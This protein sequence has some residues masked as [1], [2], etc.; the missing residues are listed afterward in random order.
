MFKMQ[1]ECVSVCV[2]LVGLVVS[3]YHQLIKI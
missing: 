3:V 1:P 2:V